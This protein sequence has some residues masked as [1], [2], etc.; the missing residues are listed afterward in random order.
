MKF[1][2]LEGGESTFSETSV[3]AS[4]TGCQFPKNIFNCHRREIIPEESGLSI[5]IV[6]LYCG[7]KLQCFHGNTTVETFNLR[8][9]EDGDD[10]NSET[11]VQVSA[12]RN[13]VQED[14]FNRRK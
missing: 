9:T 7:P 8:N 14:I 2:N 13:Q 3:K 12:T 6:P 11:W 4:A 1:K 5:L 10:T